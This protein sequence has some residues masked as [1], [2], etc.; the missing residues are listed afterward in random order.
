MNIFKAGV[1]HDDF[2]GSVAADHSDKKTFIKY[3]RDAGYAQEN[4]NLAAYRIIFNENPGEE[5]SCPGVVVYLFEGGEFT[6]KPTALRALELD[7]PIAKLLSF[8]KRFD[9]V[10]VRNGME[11]DNV[12]VDGAEE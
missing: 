9:L 1:Q 7:I 5:I 4:E 12:N 3:L 2:E 6:T 10:A 11:L 8:F